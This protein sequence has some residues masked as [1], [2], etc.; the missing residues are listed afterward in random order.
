ME[1]EQWYLNNYPSLNINIKAGH[2]HSD[3]I[4]LKFG[5]MHCG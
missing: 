3:I 5:D 1:N 4:K 2:K